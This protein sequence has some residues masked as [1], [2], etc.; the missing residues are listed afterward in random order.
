[1]F[2]NDQQV[3]E[4]GAPQ[5]EQPVDDYAGPLQTDVVGDKR[6][7]R[8]FVLPVDYA[9]G[10]EVPVGEAWQ[11]ANGDLF[12]TGLLAAILYEPIAKQR[13]K[14]ASIAFD[15]SPLQLLY[16]RLARSSFLRIE[17]KEANNG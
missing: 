11:D 1:M 13:Y 8:A 10:G 6:R 5:V 3:Q 7:L 14:S 15:I 4:L 2:P 16:Q 17:L 9:S 12:G